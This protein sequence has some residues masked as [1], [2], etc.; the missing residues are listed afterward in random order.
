[1]AEIV[2]LTDLVKTLIDEVKTL[3]AENVQLHEKID[4]IREEM[5]PKKRTTQKAPGVPKVRCS[6]IAASSGN[7]CKCRAKEGKDVCDKHEKQRQ[8]QQSQQ[9][10]TSSPQVTGSPTPKKKPRLKK[11]ANKK[12]AP[13]H[14]HPIGE[15]PRDGVI[16]ELCENHGDIFDP[17]VADPEF[18]ILPENGQ[19]IEERLRIMLENEGE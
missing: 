15:P 1:M 8:K 10:S 13:I 9:A 3:R 7:R 17:N 11:D 19:S 18:E 14:N 16:C 4:L 12:I 6:A 2:Y 5:K